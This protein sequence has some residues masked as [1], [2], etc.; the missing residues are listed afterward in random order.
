MKQQF[1]LS[2][3]S[4]FALVWNIPAQTGPVI[5]EKN[6][7]QQKTESETVELTMTLV[8]KRGKERIRKIKRFSITDENDNRSSLIRFFYPADVE[9]TGYL[10]IEHTDRDDDNWL[11]LPALNRSRRISSSDESD[12]FMSS[13]FTYEDMGTEDLQAFDYTLLGTKYVGDVECYIIKAIPSNEKKKEES[14]YSKREL[15]I[16]KDNYVTKA[17]NFYDKKDNLLKEYLAEDIR[18]IE[19]ASKWRAHKMTMD[20]KQ[21]GYKTILTFKNFNINTSVDPNIF[22]IRYLENNQ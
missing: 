11:Y 1:I 3:F 12:N 5:M 2:L 20:N 6:D 8:N 14:G 9:G 22:T 18:K 19:G 21:T 17:I 13:E 10:E 15:F 16:A 7:Q 4:L